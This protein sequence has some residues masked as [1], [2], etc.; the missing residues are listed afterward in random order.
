MEVGQEKPAGRVRI[1]FVKKTTRHACKPVWCCL[2]IAVGVEVGKKTKTVGSKGILPETGTSVRRCDAVC[3]GGGGRRKIGGKRAFFV[4]SKEREAHVQGG[5]G[6]VGVHHS[7]GGWGEKNRAEASEFCF[8][9]RDTR[10]EGRV[11]QMF[12]EERSFWSKDR[13]RHA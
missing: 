7:G 4:S 5:R 8:K 3:S 1:F 13:H 2:Y 6:A 11:R 10:M 9:K 12:S